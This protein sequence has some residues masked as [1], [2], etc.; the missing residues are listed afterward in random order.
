MSFSVARSPLRCSTAHH[1]IVSGRRHEAAPRHDRHRGDHRA[2]RGCQRLRWLA[3]TVRP[4]LFA[5]RFVHRQHRRDPAAQASTAAANLVRRMA[6]SSVRQAGTWWQADRFDRPATR[7]GASHAAR[8]AAPQAA[9]R[10]SANTAPSICYRL[11][12]HKRQ[13]F[14][15]R[16]KSNSVRLCA[17]QNDP[18]MRDAPAAT[19]KAAEN[20]AGE[21]RRIE[22]AAVRTDWLYPT[23][24]S[25][26]T[27]WPLAG[28]TPLSGLENLL[29][30]CHCSRPHA[31]PARGCRRAR[32]G[33][34]VVFGGP[35]ELSSY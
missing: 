4:R 32:F 3:T 25:S 19:I 29:A 7:F 5:K 33:S 14:N 17:R 27:C 1:V 15:P 21:R 8:S 2:L 6:G 12:R 9:A 35:S 28:V 23:R 24:P 11:K 20:A 22:V 10:P 26:A 30:E 18:D 16:P 34:A 13:S 31:E